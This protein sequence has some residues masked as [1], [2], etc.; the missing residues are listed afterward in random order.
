VREVVEDV[1]LRKQDPAGFR[2][3]EYSLQGNHYHLIV[4]VPGG[5]EGLARGLRG[6]HGA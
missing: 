2:A 1:L 6:F 4:E 5:R 3:V